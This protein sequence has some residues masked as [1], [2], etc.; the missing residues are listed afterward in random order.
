MII[1]RIEDMKH[2]WFVGGFEPTAYYTKDFEVNY[3]THP[4]GSDWDMH[5]HTDVTEI[6]LLIRGRMT[7]Q[8]QELVSGDI[9]IVGPYEVTDPV[10]I[11]DCEI[12]CVKTPSKN[13][14]QPIT[15]I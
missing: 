2:G 14:K 3:R 11:E 6:N 4:A 9:F 1:K 12:I 7:M 5:Y 13:D 15:K 8:G 10:F